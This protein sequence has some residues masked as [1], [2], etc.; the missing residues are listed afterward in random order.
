M[1]QNLSLIENPVRLFSPALVLSARLPSYHF[2]GTIGRL[3]SLLRDWIDL[4]F[5]AQ[6]CRGP[7]C[8][9]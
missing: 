8:L 1:Y 7:L 3:I 5:A 9:S 2:P 6:T 4:Q